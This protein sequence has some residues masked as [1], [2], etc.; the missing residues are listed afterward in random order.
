M[1]LQIRY[2]RVMTAA[3]V[4]PDT[5]LVP[6]QK[7]EPLKNLLKKEMISDGSVNRVSMYSK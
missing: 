4:Q 7:A 2:N 1:S 5:I 3:G 6:V